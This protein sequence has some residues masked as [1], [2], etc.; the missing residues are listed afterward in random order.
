MPV[1]V[2][3]A[4]LASQDSTISSKNDAVYFIKEAIYMNK[5]KF[6]LKGHTC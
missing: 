6:R 3:V 5:D 2:E 1:E 4:R